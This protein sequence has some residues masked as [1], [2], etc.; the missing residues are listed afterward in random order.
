MLVVRSIIGRAEEPRFAQRRVERVAVSSGDASKPRLRTTTDAG[1]DVAIDLP[2][3]SYLEDGAVLADDG[4][5]IVVVVRALE[6]ALLIRLSPDLDAAEL[7]LQAALIGHAFGNQHV[8]LEVVDG[9]VRVPI[10]TSRDIAAATVERLRL[11]DTDVSFGC[12]PLAAN[13]P[14]GSQHS[15][16]GPDAVQT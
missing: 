5:R 12:V 1:S 7:V 8:P 2:R 15:H 13:R 6:Q 4:D 3:G 10:T 11:R 9:E 14:L 16:H